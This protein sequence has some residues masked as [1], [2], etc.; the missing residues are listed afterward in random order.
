MFPSEKA[1]RR[2]FRRKAD[3]VAGLVAYCRQN[4]T[5]DDILV[6]CD[7]FSPRDPKVDK[8][9]ASGDGEFGTVYLLKSGRFYK[10]GRS[11]S[12][13]RRAYE[14]TL[15]LPERVQLVHS[16]RTDDPAG[17]EDYWHRRFDAKRTNGE[18]FNLDSS[19]VRAFKRRKS[20][21]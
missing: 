18:W 7:S 14:V 16:I 2:R 8:H 15:Q 10:I 11:N 5:C 12:P 4:S 9:Q 6:L 20:F 19:D 3:W 13:G 17:I 21:M 1:I